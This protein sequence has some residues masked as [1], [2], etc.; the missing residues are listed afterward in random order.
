MLKMKSTAPH[1]R[2]ASANAVLLAQ[3]LNQPVILVWEGSEVVIFPE[4][5]MEVAFEELWQ[6]YCADSDLPPPWC[7]C[8]AQG[9]CWAQ[10][11]TRSEAEAAAR[12][13]GPGHIVL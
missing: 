13:L 5:T 2:L 4:D 7:V 3:D 11:W 8:D 9:I 6:I 10:F 12:E 1:A